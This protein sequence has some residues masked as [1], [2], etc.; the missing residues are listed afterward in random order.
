MKKEIQ[1]LVQFALNSKNTENKKVQINLV[2]QSEAKILKLKTG[3]SLL[4]FKRVID[5]FGI[6]H[7]LKNHGDIN[8]EKLRGQI[9]ISNEDFE[10]IPKINKSK[11]LIY[12]SKNKLGN[13]AFL[14]EAII[15]DTFYYVEEVRTGK[16]ELCMTTMYKRKPTTK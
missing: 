12:V 14:Y 9:A 1:E 8:K 10:L 16:K 7:T 11:N 15:K 6:N 4:G 5:K 13:D 2:D 3:L